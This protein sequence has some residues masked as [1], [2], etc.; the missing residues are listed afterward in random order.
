MSALDAVTWSG[1]RLAEAIETVARRNGWRVDGDRE[2]PPPRGGAAGWLGQCAAAAGVDCEAVSFRYAWIDH[3]LPALGPAVLILPRDR[4]LVVVRT[5]RKYAEA[6]TPEG[7][8]ARV[9]FAELRE[10]L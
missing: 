9:A 5:R 8:I 6:L 3:E 10:A 7:T 4:F 2:L 1:G